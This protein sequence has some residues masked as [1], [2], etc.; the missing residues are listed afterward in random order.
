M[1]H[2]HTAAKEELPV[3]GFRGDN[4]LPAGGFRGDNQLPAGGFR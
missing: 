3:G 4:Q 1:L 2:T